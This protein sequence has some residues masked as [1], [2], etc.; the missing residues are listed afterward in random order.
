MEDMPKT[1]V[2]VEA[3]LLNKK[4]KMKAEKRGVKEEASSSSD[5]KL[6]FMVKIIEKLVER[7][8]L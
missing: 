8:T 5:I 6:D 2:G 7:F 1:V 4:A 3:N